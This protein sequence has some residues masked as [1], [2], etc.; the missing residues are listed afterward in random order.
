MICPSNPQAGKPQ[1][2]QLFL[3]AVVREDGS[4]AGG[5]MLWIGDP[6]PRQDVARIDFDAGVVE[7]RDGFDHVMLHGVARVRRFRNGRPVIIEDADVLVIIEPSLNADA[8][9]LIFS[10]GALGDSAHECTVIR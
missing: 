2:D 4:A 8:R 9:I 10:D 5:L 1:A 3:A 7:T 6:M